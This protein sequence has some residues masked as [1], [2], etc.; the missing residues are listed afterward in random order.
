MP[1]SK[2]CLR[3]TPLQ[4]STWCTQA[5]SIWAVEQDVVVCGNDL[6]IG[7]LTMVV[8]WHVGATRGLHHV[9]SRRELPQLSQSSQTTCAGA[10]G[11]AARHS[12]LPPAILAPGSAM[13]GPRARPALTGA[14]APQFQR[15]GKATRLGEGRQA[16]RADGRRGRMH[17]RRKGQRSLTDTPWSH[18]TC[19]EAGERDREE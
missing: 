9:H 8:A 7:A 11:F 19:C 1:W 6:G 10:H 12:A 15:R 13:P 18:Q 3:G 16:G 5:F 14:R 2:L 17:S 4:C